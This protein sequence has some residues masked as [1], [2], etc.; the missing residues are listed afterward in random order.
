VGCGEDPAAGEATFYVVGANA[1]GNCTLEFGDTDFVAAVSPDLYAGSARCGECLLVSGAAG[2]ALVKVV[3]QCPGCNAGSL[4]LTTAAFEAIVGPQSIGRDVID[5]EPVECPVAGNLNYR[6]QGSNNFFLK[7][8]VRD[9]L[10]GVEQVELDPGTGAGFTA[11][12]RTSDNHF[13]ASFPSG[14]N[15]PMSVRITSEVGEVVNDQ[16]PL[17][18]AEI[19]AGN[20]Q[21]LQGCEVRQLI[22]GDGFEG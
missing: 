15:L 6:F 10:V 16:I 8:Q 21:F 9:H 5:Y 7:L 12:T 18:N 2:V 11:L 22:F 3:D 19:Q 13:Q 20:A 1:L 17:I 4:D 14:V